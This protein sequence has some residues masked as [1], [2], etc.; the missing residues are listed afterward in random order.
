M[1]ILV[2]IV[3]GALV[4]AAAGGLLAIPALRLGGLSFALATLAFALMADNVLFPLHWF[5]G[6]QSGIEIPRPLVGP[7][8]FT[9]PTA[10][11]LLCAGVL[12][13]VAVVV[14]RIREGTTGRFLDALRGSDIAARTIGIAP[15]RTKIIA[16]AVSAGIAG[17]GGGLFGSLE[18]TVGPD[19][20]TFFSSLVFVVIVLTTGMRTVEGAMNAAVALV[21]LPQLLDLLPSRYNVLE[22]ALFGFGA[23]TFIKHPE[24]IVEFSKRRSMERLSR[25]LD[26]RRSHGGVPKPRTAAHEAPV[27]EDV[28]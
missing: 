12:V 10:F 22:F 13:A 11:F 14:V 17:L 26:R 1:S 27:P 23:I 15:A 25:F 6:G 4:A 2:A 21:L 8:D 9:D 7:I 5:G 19:R 24:G 3:I 20:F 18:G 28:R 16:L